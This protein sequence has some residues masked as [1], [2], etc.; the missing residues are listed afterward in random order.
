M[1]NTWKTQRKQELEISFLNFAI[2][3]SMKLG[4]KYSDP[5][6]SSKTFWVMCPLPTCYDF[7][8]YK[9]AGNISEESVKPERFSLTFFYYYKTGVLIKLILL[10]EEEEL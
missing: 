7:Q 8:G 10:W 6:N 3:T 1:E 5:D 4:K 9:L 2:Y